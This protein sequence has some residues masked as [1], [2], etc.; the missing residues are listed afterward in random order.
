MCVADGSPPGAG[1]GRE[2]ATSAEGTKVITTLP[3][4]LALRALGLGDLLVAVPALRGLRAAFPDHYTLLAMPPWLHPLCEL[5]GGWEP[6]SLAGLTREPPG[7]HWVDA[8]LDVAVNLHGNGAQSAALLDSM[9]PK[10]RIGHRRPGWPGPE[11]VPEL[12]ERW[13]WCRLLAAH[14]IAADESDFRL[15]A[16]GVPAAPERAIVVHPGAAYGAKRWP[17]ERFAK[18]AAA[19]RAGGHSVVI[20]GSAGERELAERLARLTGPGPEVLAGRTGLVGLAALV[21][22]ARLV[23]S[24]DT[25]VAH[26]AFAYGTPSVTL[27]GPVE[28]W[29][30]APPPG[31]PHRAPHGL[32][33]RGD[34]FADDPDPAL[35][36]VSVA[37]VLAEAAELGVPR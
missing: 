7:P 31:G 21:A 10:R 9:A 20:T 13:R 33:P 2:C 28:P 32:N 17:V 30:W 22:S 36:E 15:P 14:G 16:P 37:E 25:G 35:L 23:V 6:V 4:L 3:V 8:G 12:P 19:Y 18:V 5:I 24:G 11:W 29:R 1:S 26:L 27:Y 34:P